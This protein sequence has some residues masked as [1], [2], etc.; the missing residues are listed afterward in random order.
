MKRYYGKKYKLSIQR[1]IIYEKKREMLLAKSN[2]NQQNR[3]YAGKKYKQQIEKLQ[4][5]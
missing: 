3:N 4:K 2:L 1:K 5:G